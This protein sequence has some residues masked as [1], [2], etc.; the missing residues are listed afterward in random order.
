MCPSNFPRNS[1]AY[2]LISSQHVSRIVVKLCFSHVVIAMTRP[3]ENVF[4]HWLCCS[5][6]DA[7]EN[8]CDHYV[9]FF[10]LFFVFLNG[11]F[12]ND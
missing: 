11:S 12:L 7:N 2:R 9:V 6:E 4:P 8:L 3:R 5:N 1:V 10:L